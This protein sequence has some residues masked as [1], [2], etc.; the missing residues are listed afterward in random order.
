MSDSPYL[1]AVYASQ[2]SGGL[3]FIGYVTSDTQDHAAEEFFSSHP[4]I[5][6]P[7]NS[8]IKYLGYA[9]ENEYLLCFGGNEFSFYLFRPTTNAGSLEFLDLALKF[10]GCQHNHNY[11]PQVNEAD[12]KKYFEVF[13]P[14]VDEHCTLISSAAQDIPSIFPAILPPQIILTY[15]DFC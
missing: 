3:G 4:H 5:K 14:L 11:A 12:L 2:S 7:K 13:R 15:G 10:H 8:A 6:P 9:I 1:F